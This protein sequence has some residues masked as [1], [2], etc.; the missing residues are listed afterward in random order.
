MIK[1]IQISLFAAAC[2]SASAQAALPIAPNTF[3]FNVTTINYNAN[4][5]GYAHYIEG[6]SNGVNWDMYANSLWNA[7]TYTND[8]FNYASSG[9]YGIDSLHPGADFKIEFDRPI[10]SLLVLLS[11]DNLADSIN[12]GNHYTVGDSSGITYDNLSGQ[13][14][15]NSASGGWI[16]FND[17]QSNTI[18]HTNNN[19]INDG[20]DMAFHVV[21]TVPEPSTLGL[22]FGG[23]GLIGLIAARR[24][25]G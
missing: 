11:N 17:I 4:Q 18:F 16:L 22:M 7:R 20:F 25:N 24:Q 6:N 9:V 8:R 1:H 10:G 13:V 14:T 15:L 19:G 5:N 3:D 23:L 12:F 21:S 2:F